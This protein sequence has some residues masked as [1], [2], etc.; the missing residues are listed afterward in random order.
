MSMNS[1]SA[2]LSDGLCEHAARVS[3]ITR[4]AL[5]ETGIVA[6]SLERLYGIGS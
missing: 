2:S 6:I 4:T 5:R 1:R 3:A